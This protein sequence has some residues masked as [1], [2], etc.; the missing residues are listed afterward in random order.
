MANQMWCD[1][2]IIQR[3]K[4]TE[5]AVGVGLGSNRE[6]GGVGQNLKREIGNNGG[7]LHSE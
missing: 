5:R 3:N 6:G 7:G 1:H 2:S 4:T